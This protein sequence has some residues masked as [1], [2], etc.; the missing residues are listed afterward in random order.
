MQLG[1]LSEQIRVS[2]L[3]ARLLVSFIFLD[4]ISCS[5][6]TKLNASF[7]NLNTRICNQNPI[8]LMYFSLSP[9]NMVLN[10]MGTSTGRRMYSVA[11]SPPV[12]IQ[13]RLAQARRWRWGRWKRA[14]WFRLPHSTP[15]SRPGCGRPPMMPQVNKPPI[16]AH[17]YRVTHQFEPNLPLS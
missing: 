15:E 11:R 7:H 6:S 14:T 16:I 5:F 4:G 13:I 2:Y 9:Q 17:T 10:I 12:V 8:S 1:W 3:Q